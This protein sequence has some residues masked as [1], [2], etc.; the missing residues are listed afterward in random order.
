MFEVKCCDLLCSCL[1]SVWLYNTLTVCAPTNRSAW[2]DF[3]HYTLLLFQSLGESGHDSQ[4]CR[5]SVSHRPEEPPWE[6]PCAAFHPPSLRFT[7]ASLPVIESLTQVFS[8]YAP[9]SLTSHPRGYIKICAQK[10]SWKW[11]TLLP[12]IPPLHPH[13]HVKTVTVGGLQGKVAKH[14]GPQSMSAAERF[15]TC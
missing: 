5:E 14:L 11:D 15:S 7:C 12:P 1:V 4:T 6:L 2:M 3:T 8:R 9:S 10:E 13:V